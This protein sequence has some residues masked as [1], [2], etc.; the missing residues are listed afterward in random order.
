M[1]VVAWLFNSILGN[2]ILTFVAAIAFMLAIG[3]IFNPSGLGEIVYL[4]AYFVIFQ[5]VYAIFGPGKNALIPNEQRKSLRIAAIAIPIGMITTFGIINF[6]IP[7]LAGTMSTVFFF[8]PALF[9]IYLGIKVP[10]FK[11]FDVWQADVPFEDKDDSKMRPVITIGTSKLGH[12]DMIEC[13][14]VTSK[15]KDFDANFRGISALNWDLGPAE[16]RLP[17]SWV[18]INKSVSLS[19]SSFNR[20]LGTVDANDIPKL[21]RAL[22]DHGLLPENPRYA[23]D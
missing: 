7:A 10:K 12:E 11:L 16:S 6:L 23:V 20:F 4:I 1:R 21:E 2:A 5:A 18:R 17:R 8:A 14:Y 9:V 22:S 3:A 13:L 15:D 19:Q